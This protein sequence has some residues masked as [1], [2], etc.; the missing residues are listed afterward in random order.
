MVFNLKRIILI[1][2][3]ALYFA[4]A[5]PFNIFKSRVNNDRRDP[6]FLVARAVPKEGA[7][8]QDLAAPTTTFVMATATVTPIYPTPLVVKEF[9]KNAIPPIGAVA[10]VNHKFAPINV[11]EIEAAAIIIPA[12]GIAANAIKHNPNPLFPFIGEKSKHHHKSKTKS[13][14][15]S[16]S[17][18]ESSSTSTSE[19]S[20][21]STS[22]SSPTSSSQPQSDNNT[23]NINSSANSSVL[24]AAVGIGVG[25]AGVAASA[26]GAFFFIKSRKKKDDG[27]SKDGKNG[28]DDDPN[29]EKIFITHHGPS[30]S[31][32]DPDNDDNTTKPSTREPTSD[33][34]FGSQ[35]AST[36]MVDLGQDTGQG[37]V[38]ST[39][40]SRHHSD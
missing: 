26:I 21:T 10:I 12:A 37:N 33:T 39:E 35:A 20:S 16:T 15:S 17:T 1:V 28:K 13:E 24:Q 40:M 2:L 25:L 5:H 7:V 4:A 18:S 38:G 9:S 23:N 36:S 19:S 29:K 8:A 14:S 34:I 30:E 31:F 3:F 32:V 11:S 27:D 22:E 6:I